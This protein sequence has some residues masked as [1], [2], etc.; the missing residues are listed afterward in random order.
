MEAWG[1]SQRFIFVINVFD[2]FTFYVFVF[3]RVLLLL[4][5][6]ESA[7]TSFGFLLGLYFKLHGVHRPNSMKKTL[8]KR[9][10]SAE[11]LLPGRM[12]DQAAA[13]AL[14]HIH[15]SP[16]STGKAHRSGVINPD[17]TV[18]RHLVTATSYLTQC[19]EI[20]AILG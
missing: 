8:I 20:G 1:F 3:L 5:W 4:D 10:K 2:A 18:R 12:S 7:H 9:R 6:D 17:D 13:E 11:M 15:V 16:G 19:L 14:R